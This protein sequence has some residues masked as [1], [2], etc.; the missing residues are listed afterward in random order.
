MDQQCN[1]SLFFKFIFYV[2]NQKTFFSLYILIIWNLKQEMTLYQITCTSYTNKP[3]SFNLA[4]KIWNE[5]L[6]PTPS[7]YNVFHARIN[8]LIVKITQQQIWYWLFAFSLL[9]C[10]LKLR[11]S[12]MSHNWDK[13]ELLRQI[14]CLIMI[15]SL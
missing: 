5:R 6:L 9:L 2:A 3:T 1:K 7:T 4:L 13:F 10:I 8:K 11:L 12:L 14:I 15:E